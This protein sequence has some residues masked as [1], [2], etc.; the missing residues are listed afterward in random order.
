MP[1]LRR[2]LIEE[3]AAEAVAGVGDEQVDFAAAGGVEQPVHSGKGGEVRLDVAYLHPV[4]FE[5]ARCIDQ[6]RVGGDDQVV[7]V[8]GGEPGQLEADPARGS[9]DDREPACS[10]H[11]PSSV[12]FLLQP[13]GERP[14]PILIKFAKQRVAG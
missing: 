11:G 5:L 14:V 13:R 12:K 2:V 1:P 10:C 7:A 8:P 9:G 4:S 6:G 3:G